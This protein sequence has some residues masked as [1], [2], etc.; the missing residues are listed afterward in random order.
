MWLVLPATLGPR[1]SLHQLPGVL[2]NASLQLRYC[3]SLK[4]AALPKIKPL[5]R[6]NVTQGRFEGA[7]TQPLS[8]NQDNWQEPCLLRSSHG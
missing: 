6:G 3:P 4:R 1:H 8:S 2:A 5:P 7:K